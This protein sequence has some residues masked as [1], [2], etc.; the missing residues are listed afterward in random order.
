M[1]KLHTI[2]ILSV[3]LLGMSACEKM[4]DVPSKRAVS[5]EDMWL[6]MNDA[7]AALSACY[8]L[9]R[10]AILNENAYW[11]YGELRGGDFSVT[12]RTDLK[13][14]RTNDL[15]ADYETMNQ[16]R[17]W[18]RFYAA[19]GQC[20]LVIEN[21]PKVVGRDFRYSKEDMRLDRAQAYYLRSFLYFYLTKVWGDVPLVLHPAD[22]SFSKK[23]RTSR[24]I[25]LDSALKD[26]DRAKNGLPWEYNGEWPEQQGQYRGQSVEGHFLSIAATKGAS[27]DLLA[28]IHAWQGEY[29]RALHYCDSLIDNQSST[30]YVLVGV[31]ELTRN[32]DFGG[33]FRGRNYNN[34]WQIDM[35]FDHAEI[36]TTGQLEDWTLRSPHIPKDFSTIYVSKDSI[37]SIYSDSHDQRKEAFF[38]GL[39]DAYPEF[40]KVNRV[41]SVVQDP[42][43]RYYSSAII[44]F[45]YEELYLL[46]AECRAHQGDVPGAIDDLNMVR[47][48]RSLSGLS[49]TFGNQDIVLDLILEERR[50]EL[51]GEGWRWFDLVRFGKVDQYTDLTKGD[52]D[53]G[54]VYWPVSDEVIS[55]NNKIKQNPFW[56]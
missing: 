32:E 23:E 33:S 37:Q 13:A 49:E 2:L 12:S 3:L 47:T 50:R 28:H 17:D 19:I 56:E 14:L 31:D 39:T 52:V 25:V 6:G 35:N 38:R 51:I 9:T 16:W 43:L 42:T 55:L 11:V 4:L 54:A 26:A 7:R 15:N 24:K 1:R 29:G 53:N 27:L 46:R 21:I 5:E 20:N 48:E 40:Y 44:L 18:R 8:A 30:K 10:A 45:R 22:G 34:I 41:H 36:S